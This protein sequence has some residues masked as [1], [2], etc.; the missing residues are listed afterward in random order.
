MPAPDDNTT[1]PRSGVRRL[2]SPFELR[3]LR[4]AAGL[5]FTA[6]GFQLGIGVVLLGLGRRAE[7]APERRKCDRWAAWFLVNAALQLTGGCMD[8]VAD[9]PARTRT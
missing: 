9:R 8:M 3:H 6:G 5:R 7:T 4:S 2:I 1:P